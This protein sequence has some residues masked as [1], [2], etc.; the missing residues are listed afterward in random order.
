MQGARLADIVLTEPEPEALGL[1]P[2]VDMTLQLTDVWFRYS[3]SD[4][5]VVQG[6]NLTIQ[7]GESVA[8]VGGSGCGKLPC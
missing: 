8:I 1:L 6:V 2:P 5:W 7:A 3:E 4:P